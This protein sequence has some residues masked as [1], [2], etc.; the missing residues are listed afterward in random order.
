MYV[1]AA[2]IIFIVGCALLAD[3][4]AGDLSKRKHEDWLRVPTI[5]EY[6]RKTQ[7]SRIQCW[8]CRSCSIRQYGLEARNDKRRIHACNQCNTKLYRTTRS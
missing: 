8:H 5:E 7:L 2:F 6:A 3:W 1:I 4:L